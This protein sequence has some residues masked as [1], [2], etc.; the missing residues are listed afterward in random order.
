M[1][2]TYA[3]IPFFELSKNN[4]FCYDCGIAEECLNEYDDHLVETS[5]HQ[6]QA[7]DIFGS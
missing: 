4:S 5:F 1:M 2:I 6:S 7:S 3:D